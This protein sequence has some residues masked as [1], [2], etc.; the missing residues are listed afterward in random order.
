M[1]PLATAIYNKGSNDTDFMDSVNDFSFMKSTSTKPYSTF[2]MISDVPSYTF[3]ANKALENTLWQLDI[4]AESGLGAG[5]IVENAKACFD[6]ADLSV[7]GYDHLRCK[8][9]NSNLLYE[10]DTETYHYYIEYRVMVEES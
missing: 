5:N 8:R 2:Q 3:G 10:E 9:E 7:T 6:E 4:W 1:N